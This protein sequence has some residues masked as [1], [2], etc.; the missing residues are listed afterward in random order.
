MANAHGG[1]KNPLPSKRNPIRKATFSEF[2]INAENPPR[3]LRALLAF[4]NTHPAGGL[5]F[6]SIWRAM[7][8]IELPPNYDSMIAKLI[9]KAKIARKRSLTQSGL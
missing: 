3:I 8:V 5:M 7:V 2:R 4:L 6:A 9:I 1:G